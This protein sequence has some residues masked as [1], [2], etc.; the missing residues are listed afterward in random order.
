MHV[1]DDVREA[2]VAIPVRARTADF[3]KIYQR[4]AAHLVQQLV[5]LVDLETQR[6]GDFL[7]ACRSPSRCS[8][9]P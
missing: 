7:F 8:T 5:E 6:I 4:D 1:L 3:F 9:S 2:S